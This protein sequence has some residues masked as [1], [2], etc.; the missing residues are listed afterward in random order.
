MR[1]KL[2]YLCGLAALVLLAACQNDDLPNGGDHTTGTAA[3]TFHV[4]T[5]A[6]QQPDG[7]QEVRLYVAERRQENDQ[8]ELYASAIHDVSN[9]SFLLERMTA[10]WYKL[11]FIA[12]PDLLENK[13]PAIPADSAFNN[14]TLDYSPVLARNNQPE[15]D[16][17]EDLAIYRTVIDRW[18]MPDERLTEDVTLKRITG[19]LILDMGILNDQFPT[20]VTEIKV[21]LA[22]VPS[23][24]YLHD[25]GNGEIICKNSQTRTYIFEDIDWD[26]K[27]HFRACFNLLPYTIGTDDTKATVTVTL[28]GENGTEVEIDFPLVQGKHNT[29]EANAIEIKPNVLTTV[30]FRGMESN[31]FEVR[32]AGFDGMSIE[33]EDEWNGWK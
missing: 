33:V 18:L 21:E 25:Q 9:G 1:Q 17:T 10:Q 15:D 3:A 14:L 30:Y 22:G 11:A 20:R 2:T 24:V 4:F 29:G 12:V 8:D 27:D 32:Y 31:E 7:N 23:T 5:R 13:L 19:R 26:S 28:E 6:A 16:D